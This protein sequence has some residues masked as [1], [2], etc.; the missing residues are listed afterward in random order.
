MEKLIGVYKKEDKKQKELF[1]YFLDDILEIIAT[2]IEEP[3]GSGCGYGMRLEG[4]DR[5]EQLIS[6][7]GVTF[8]NPNKT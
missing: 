7:F 5:L 4:Y 8:K 2:E 3:A 6:E 1:N